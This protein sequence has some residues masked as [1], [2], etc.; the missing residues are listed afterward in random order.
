MQSVARPW[1]DGAALVCVR[2]YVATSEE[3]GVA[4]RVLPGPW[5]RAEAAISFLTQAP[6]QAVMQL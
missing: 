4:R 3:P 1:N 6:S 2:R 5:A